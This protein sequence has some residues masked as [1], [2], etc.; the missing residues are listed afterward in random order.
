[1][2]TKTLLSS[3]SATN[4]FLRSAT[5]DDVSKLLIA[6]KRGAKRRTML[7]RLHARFNLLRARREREELNALADGR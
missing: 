2:D 5:E 6:E 4:D 1:M 7:L 3:F